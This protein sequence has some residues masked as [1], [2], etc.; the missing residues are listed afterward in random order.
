LAVSCGTASSHHKRFFLLFYFILF[1]GEEIIARAQGVYVFQPLSSNNQ[2]LIGELY[3][4]NF[5]L[6]FQTI[7][8]PDYRWKHYHRVQGLF[9]NCSFASDFEVVKI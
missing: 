8:F 5:K 3:I 9:P 2:G 7:T 6:S 4:T 1:S